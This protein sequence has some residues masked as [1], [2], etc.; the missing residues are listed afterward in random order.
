MSDDSE[1]TAVIAGGTG[2]LG[3][4]FSAYSGV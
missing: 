4:D 3:G 1:K 2:A